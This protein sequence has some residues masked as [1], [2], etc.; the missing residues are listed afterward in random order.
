M[1]TASQ[2]LLDSLAEEPNAYAVRDTVYTIAVATRTTS[3]FGPSGSLKKANSV[4]ENTTEVM[5]K[6]SSERFLVIA[7]NLTWDE[8]KTLPLTD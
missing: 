8:F 7:L 4:L 2:N 3:K 1:S 5:P 6:M